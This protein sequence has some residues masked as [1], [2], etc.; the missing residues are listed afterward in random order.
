MKYLFFQDLKL[1][2]RESDRQRKA[3]LKNL[4]REKRLMLILD[5]DH[6]LLNSTRLAD[7]SLEEEYLLR[8]ADSIKGISCF[9]VLV[10]VNCNGY[11]V[12]KLLAVLL[13]VSFFPFIQNILV[14]K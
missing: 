11:C 13:L 1:G 5:L 4:L 10:V 14:P 8:Q 2:T 12:C 3:D 9:L 6:T 7:V